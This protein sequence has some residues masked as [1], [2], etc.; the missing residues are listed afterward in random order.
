MSPGT[1]DA[2]GGVGL[3]ANSEVIIQIDVAKAMSKG[4][5]F[6]RYRDTHTHAYAD[7]G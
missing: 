6:Y 3:P 5:R 1:P 7:K 2:P 4:I